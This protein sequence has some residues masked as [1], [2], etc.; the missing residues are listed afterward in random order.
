MEALRSNVNNM[1]NYPSEETM[2]LFLELWNDVKLWNNKSILHTL[3]DSE[4][5]SRYYNINAVTTLAVVCDYLCQKWKE[6]EKKAFIEEL[7]KEG[8]MFYKKIWELA[9]NI[10][11]EKWDLTAFSQ[12]MLESNKEWLKDST[13]DN[14]Y[15]PVI[16]TKFF[17]KRIQDI[18]STKIIHE[19]FESELARLKWISE[20][21]NQIQAESENHKFDRWD[22]S[23]KINDLEN[24]L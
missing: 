24:Q 22:N 4:W 3:K 9:L 7:K 8:A 23:K 19:E 17:P 10:R 13:P 2:E 16:V 14:P 18:K 12:S 20:W 5:N 15:F 1:S 11:E 6:N 21:A